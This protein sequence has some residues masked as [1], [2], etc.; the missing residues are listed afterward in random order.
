[1]EILLN[2][3]VLILLSIKV[4]ACKKQNL[5]ENFIFTKSTEFLPYEENLKIYFPSSNENDID[6]D[7][8]IYYLYVQIYN[9]LNLL[10]PKRDIS[11]IPISDKEMH[12]KLVKFWK[13]YSKTYSLNTFQVVFLNIDN[14]NKYFEENLNEEFLLKL[15]KSVFL[16]TKLA[17]YPLQISLVPLYS[18]NLS[19]KVIDIFRN[20]WKD[21]II[22]RDN[23]NI[24]N[25]S[26]KGHIYEV[27]E[28]LDFGFVPLGRMIKSKKEAKECWIWLKS[29]GV[30]K[31][32]WKPVLLN[33]G[34]GHRKIRNDSDLDKILNNYYDISNFTMPVVIQEYIDLEYN[35]MGEVKSINNNYIGLKQT[36]PI[37]EQIHEG[38][39]FVGFR[40]PAEI[41]K[42]EKDTITKI[43]NILYNHFK[44][45]YT[46]CFDTISD[47]KS[48]LYVIDLNTGR[49]CGCHYLK[50]FIMRNIPNFKGK[51]G[52]FKTIIEA[53]FLKFDKVLET[54]NE[55]DLLI[56]AKKIANSKLKSNGLTG[57]I[58][59]AH[60]YLD[61]TVFAMFG[62]DKS[63]L[64]TIFETFK[65]SLKAKLDEIFEEE[66]D[67]LA[68]Y[69]KEQL[70]KTNREN[71]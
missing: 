6:K 24:S 23:P 57:I 50:L 3:I 8:D 48:K 70:R 30:V 10:R 39:A 26:S 41:N 66:D 12:A 33:G 32:I 13:W 35:E 63:D 37:S 51:F 27:Q 18:K 65:S 46:W 14:N 21:I 19:N 60:S 22:E 7:N 4:D 61:F 2:F 29:Q 36:G 11:I 42:S 17:K 52:I 64:N 16:L 5:V 45:K 68:L 53:K 15:E 71:K 59:F 67:N 38:D 40:A 69:F 62:K 1:M 31:A 47:K 54:L 25:I 55:L 20:K 43:G 9:S 56:D 34:A 49:Y 58:P 28:L 44:P